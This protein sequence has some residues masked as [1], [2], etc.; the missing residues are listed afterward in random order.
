M[1]IPVTGLMGSVS[2]RLRGRWSRS[3]RRLTIGVTFV[4]SNTN[5]VFIVAMRHQRSHEKDGRMQ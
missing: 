4:R 5:K 3:V 1:G 2:G